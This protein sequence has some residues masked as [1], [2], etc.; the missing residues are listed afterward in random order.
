MK[1]NS[2]N[3]YSS[4][5]GSEEDTKY[6]TSIVR[7]NSAHISEMFT[8]LMGSYGN[9]NCKSLN[10]A[11]DETT[12]KIYIEA[13]T[14]GF[15]VVHIPFNFASYIK[16]KDKE[17]SKFWLDHIMLAISFAGTL[18]HWDLDFFVAIASKIEQLGYKNQWRA[19]KYTKSPSGNWNGA[20]WVEESL[21]YTE[22]YFL[23]L[24][25]R[26][27]YKRILLKRTAPSIWNYYMYLGKIHWIGETGIEVFKS[28]KVL[29]YIPDIF[30]D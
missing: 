22:I 2:I 24:K 13:S 16:L 3:I 8:R 15:P 10:I 12:E 14:D 28:E 21:E 18:W 7:N 1:F 29:F 17:I 30:A 25:K 27:E 19:G 20:I 11:C 6:I 26:T 23:L 5:R 9:N 4:Y